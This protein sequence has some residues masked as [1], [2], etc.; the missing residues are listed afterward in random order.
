MKNLLNILSIFKDSSK[1]IKNSDKLRLITLGDFP[2]DHSM[3]ILRISNV[4][5]AHSIESKTRAH[6]IILIQRDTLDS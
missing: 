1:Y 3:Q 6:A 5:Y 2:L 4:S